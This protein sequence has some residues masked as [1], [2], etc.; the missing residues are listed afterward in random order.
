MGKTVK[1]WNIFL[2]IAA[3]ACL[4]YYDYRGGLWLKGVTSLWFVLIGLVNVIYGWK[5]GCR[6]R[7]FLLLVEAALVCA[8]AADVIL[9]IDFMVG[10]LVFG[11]GHVMNFAAFCS[12]EKLS[13][14]DILPTLAAAAVSLWAVFGTPYIRVEQSFMRYLLMGY[15]VVISLMLG[16]AI[17]NLLVH[18]SGSRWLLAISSAMFW[19]SDLMLALNLFGSGGRVASLLCMYTYWPGQSLLAHTLLH[20]VDEQESFCVSGAN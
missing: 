16:K 18:K 6:G 4:V 10:A 17:G 20:F 3:M 11:A 7:R 15:A 2:M 19:F 1:K 12:L 13:R 5:T 8:M 9:G 14:R